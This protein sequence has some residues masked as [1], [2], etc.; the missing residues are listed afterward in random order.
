MRKYKTNN[1]KRGDI[2]Y[3]ELEGRGCQQKGIRP[4]VVYSNN[5]N[6]YHSPTLNIF[7]VTK[8]M[9]DLCVHVYIE[10]C[11]LREPSMVLCEQI[12]TINKDQLLEK[13]GT[14]TDE[15]MERIDDAVDIQ[16]G[17][18]PRPST[19]RDYIKRFGDPFEVA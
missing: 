9:K 1:I 12:R 16:F 14:L 15:D 19:R 8:Q 11:G 10:G 4:V 7:P 6:N 2:F 5:M 3:A 18:K 13:I 17:R